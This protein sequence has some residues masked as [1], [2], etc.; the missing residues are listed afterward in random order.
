MKHNLISLLILFLPVSLSAQ[1]MKFQ[2]RGVIG[3]DVEIVKGLKL[4]GNFETRSDDFLKSASRYDIEFVLDYKVNDWMKVSTIYESV[5]KYNSERVK[6]STNRY[7]LRAT[8]G[9]KYGNW[10]FSL[11]ETFY[12]YDKLYDVNTYQEALNDLVLKSRFKVAYKGYEKIEPYCYFELRHNLN[13]V[14]YSSDGIESFNF[15]GYN[16]AFLSRVRGAAG[17]EWNVSKSTSV[18][19]TILDDY[20]FERDIDVNK[21]GTVLKSFDEY[22]TNKLSFKVSVNYSFGRILKK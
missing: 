15:E 13:A 1:E 20:V 11:R 22:N 6:K 2:E 5:N 7:G 21:E 18:D 12:L 9:K 16:H 14:S 3:C 10:D 17:L 19:F 4:N 8:A